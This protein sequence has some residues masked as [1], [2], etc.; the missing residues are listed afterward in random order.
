MTFQFKATK[1]QIRQ[2]GANAIDYSRPIGL[3]FL[4]HRSDL[5]IRIEDIELEDGN[6][7]LDYVAGR[8]VKLFIRNIGDEMWEIPDSPTPDY[9]TWVTKYPTNEALV[10]SVVKCDRR[11]D[12]H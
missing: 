5:V 9:Q 6:L 4:Y 8:C 2:I 3:G 12:K 10:E 11:L 1:E 7:N